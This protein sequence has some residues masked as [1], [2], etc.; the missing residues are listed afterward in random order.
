[1]LWLTLISSN[2]PCVEHIFMVPRWSSH[3][4]STVLILLK[5]MGT[6]SC[7]LRIFTK[8]NNFTDILFNS[9]A[10][11]AFSKCYLL[12]R[13]FPV[14]IAHTRLVQ[15][16]FRLSDYPTI[17]LYRYTVCD[18]VRQIKHGWGCID[19]LMVL[20]TG[21]RP[22]DICRTADKYA[23]QLTNLR[24]FWINPGSFKTVKRKSLV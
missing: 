2:S 8:C 15:I 1:M 20:L 23:E 22:F 11:K 16:S 5:C 17:Q 6:S 18:S 12:L 7:F 19:W 3:W 21:K 13:Y 24:H 9:L 10:G 14:P 4:S